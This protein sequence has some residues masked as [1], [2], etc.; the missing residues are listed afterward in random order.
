M[1]TLTKE[2]VRIIRLHSEVSITRAKIPY[3]IDYPLKLY[4]SGNEMNKISSV[5]M[6]R[7]LDGAGAAN[8]A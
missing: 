6:T 4:T 3:S 8:N 2:S 1:F 7:K 5:V